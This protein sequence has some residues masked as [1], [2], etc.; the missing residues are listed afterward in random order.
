MSGA[1]QMPGFAL[2]PLLELFIRQAWTYD[3]ALDF[4]RSLEREPWLLRDRRR[5]Y[6]LGDRLAAFGDKN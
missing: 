6:E 3:V 5:R 4:G 1:M 2:K